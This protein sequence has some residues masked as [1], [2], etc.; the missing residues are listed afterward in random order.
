MS[1]L[2][3]AVLSDASPY[4]A[5]F[6][7][8]TAAVPQPSG[9]PDVGGGE[10]PPGADDLLKVL[11]WVAWSVT[12]LCVGGILSVAARMAIDHSRGGSRE[13][14]RGLSFVL[15]ACMLVGSASGIVGALI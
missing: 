15:G 12:A 11:R 8:L 10:A 14:A 1:S 4:A 7:R 6:A 9:V 13:H 5:H 3:A 2:L